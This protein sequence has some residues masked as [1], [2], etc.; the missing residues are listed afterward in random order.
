MDGITFHALRARTSITMECLIHRHGISCDIQL[1]HLIYSKEGV[2]INHTVLSHT[3]P[4]RSFLQR[5]EMSCW[6]HKRSTNLERVPCKGELSFTMQCMYWIREIFMWCFVTN[7]KNT[8]VHK[9][10]AWKQR[11]P[12][13]SSLSKTNCETSCFSPHNSGICNVEV[14]HSYQGQRSYRKSPIKLQAVIATGQFGG[15]RVYR[16]IDSKYS[17]HPFG[18]N[19]P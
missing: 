15:P 11:W 7:R 13:L 18:D 4:S 3:A 6:R 5:D 10:R 14:L 16:P 12:Y 8:W 9:V 19:S 17:C 1:R 2:R